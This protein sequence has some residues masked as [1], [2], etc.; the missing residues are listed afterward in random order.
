MPSLRHTAGKTEKWRNDNS[1]ERTTSLPLFHL[2]P[3]AKFIPSMESL[4]QPLPFQHY[5]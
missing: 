3:A 2:I 1:K 4:G 5:D